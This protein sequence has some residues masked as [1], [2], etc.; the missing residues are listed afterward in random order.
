MKITCPVLNAQEL[1][2]HEAKRE[3]KRDEGT[4]QIWKI[5]LISNT[6]SGT[7]GCHFGSNRVAILA[8]F[9]HIC[10]VESIRAWTEELMESLKGLNVLL[11]HHSLQQ[12][13]WCDD[14]STGQKA[15]RVSGLKHGGPCRCWR[16]PAGDPL[17]C[18]PTATAA[19]GEKTVRWST[20]STHTIY[21]WVCVFLCLFFSSD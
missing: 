13:D 5:M 12:Q 10:S 21:A 11:W 8:G 18:V 14:R 9:V 19:A 17:T 7:L 16:D 1:R 2:I 20:P 4:W 3:K 6:I 15:K